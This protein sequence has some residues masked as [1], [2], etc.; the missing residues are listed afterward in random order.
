[1]IGLGSDKNK[2]NYSFFG[3]FIGNNN[4][5]DWRWSLRD[6]WDGR[7]TSLIKFQCQSRFVTALVRLFHEMS[8]LWFEP[9]KCSLIKH[10][11]IAS[12][13]PRPCL[14]LGEFHT[15]PTAADEALMS[16]SVR[17]TLHLSHILYF[18]YFWLFVIY[19]LTTIVQQKS[20]GKSWKEEKMKMKM[21]LIWTKNDK[22]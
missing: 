4:P 19:F 9:F 1:M 5:G 8:F 14:L 21:I 6:L 17:P 10:F 2:V 7:D 11:C 18:C 3:V 15:K 16:V 13:L 20:V 12:S 22:Y